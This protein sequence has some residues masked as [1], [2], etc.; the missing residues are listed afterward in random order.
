MDPVSKLKL[1]IAPIE[2]LKYLFFGGSRA[3]EM[4]IMLIIIAFIHISLVGFSIATTIISN[5]ITFCTNRVA[6]F[7]GVA[8]FGGGKISFGF[9][10]GS[11]NFEK[12][13]VFGCD[14]IARFVTIFDVNTGVLRI[15]VG[16]G[17]GVDG[18]VLRVGFLDIYFGFN[19]HI[20]VVLNDYRNFRGVTKKLLGGCRRTR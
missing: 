4:R 13:K 17:S 8:T 12:G 3:I 2:I 9:R 15:L 20:R 5:T 18:I 16:G 19:F 14:I 11:V 6:G 10:V 1:I 7:V